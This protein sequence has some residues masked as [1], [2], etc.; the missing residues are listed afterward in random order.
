MEKKK[1]FIISAVYYSLI[2]AIIFLSL[3]YA[4][5]L[6]MPFIIGFGAA[7]VL[8]PIV[9]FFCRKFNMKR[10]PTALF[11][12]LIFYIAIGLFFSVITVRTAVWI[13]EFFKK[14]PEI[15]TDNFEPAITDLFD[16]TQELFTSFN[17]SSDSLAV[18]I[19][20]L[21]DYAKS[22]IGSMVSNISVRVISGIS[23]FATSIPTFMVSLL[24]AVISSFFFIIDYEKLIKT[25]KSRLSDKTVGILKKLRSHFF[26]AIFKYLRSYSLIMLI[27][28]SELF[29]GFTLIG[30]R[31]SLPL[32]A[33]VAFLDILPV[34][35]TGVVILPWAVIS[36]IKNDLRIGIGLI[37]LWIIT[38]VIR[39]IIEPKIV[40]RQVGL[41]PLATL[42]AMFVGAKLIGF[43]GLLAAPLCLSVG[44][45]AYREN[46]KMEIKN[47]KDFEYE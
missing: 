10:H 20:E 27:T 29:F 34:I 5:F 35:G 38:L 12:L 23:S 19:N 6:V 7:T 22:S 9:R 26:T 28:F 36:L 16:R 37:L 21:L 39:N 43:I 11:V 14:L 2:G 1:H 3:K 32:A 44:L 8:N 13:G 4:L 47:D 41:P 31:N 40:G 17:G 33:I 15:Y 25:A 42:I 46:K 24:F 30:I 18:G 45:S